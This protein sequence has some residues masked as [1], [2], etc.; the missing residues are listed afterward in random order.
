MKRF[1]LKVLSFFVLYLFLTPFPVLA[2][3]P[4]QTVA[5]VPFEI[6]SA[7]NLD[8]VRNGM[9]YMLRSR[10]SWQDKVVVTPKRQ[11]EK[12]LA[13]LGNARPNE[14]LKEVADKTQSDFIMAGSI[15][16]LAGSFSIDAK[17][18]DIPNKRY[19]AFFE[20]SNNSD[21]LIDKI[22]RITASINQK[23]FNRTTVTW[24]RMEQERQAHIN[25]LKRKNP[26]HLMNNPYWQ[27]QAED[28][29]GWKIWK[30][31]F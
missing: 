28:D 9:L 17:I 5:I 11:I 2:S 29:P 12:V 3:D 25:E 26:E 6:H 4:V 1:T 7:E 16:Q 19:L 31:L 21:D 14:Q 20:Q 27:Q 13:N 8:H 18:Y 23:V 30:Y 24:E 10:L 22:D 15:T